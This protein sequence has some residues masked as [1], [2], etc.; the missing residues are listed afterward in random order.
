MSINIREY[1]DDH[2]EAVRR[3]NERLRTGGLN[4]HFFESCVPHGLAKLPGRKLYEEHFLALEGPVV[5]GAYGLKHQD[6]WIAG[7]AVSIADF[8]LPISEGTVDKTYAPV[9]VALL[10]DAQRRQPLLYGLGMGGYDEA[11]VRLLAAS[12]W[13]TWTV[14]FFFRVVH[15]AAFLR[16]LAYVRR[17]RAR[18]LALDLLAATGLGWLGLKTAQRVCRPAARRESAVNAE[19]VADFSDRADALWDACK[20][21]YGLSAVRDLATLRILY[22]ASE[23]KFIR[24]K[25]TRRNSCIGWAVLLNTQL[26]GHKQFGNMRL[27]SLVDC[28]ALPTDARA[29]VAAARD[30]LENRGVDLI[31]SNQ[32]HAAW[33]TALKTAGFLSGPSNFLFAASPRLA[34]ALQA[35]NVQNA[36]FHLNRGDGDGPINL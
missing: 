6:F 5:R 8:W 28:L 16:N 22:P 1:T 30:F 24:L 18:T 31:V 17:G 26:A 4:M 36:D 20:Q 13:R 34:D 33:G 9:G 11:L 2:V 10:L 19:N 27:G 3:F 35:A 32:A 25:V 21:D 23:A 29:V 14:P 15:P 12:R 7:R